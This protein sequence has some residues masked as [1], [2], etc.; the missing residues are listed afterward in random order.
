MSV[1][2]GCDNLNLQFIRNAFDGMVTRARKC[3][4][5]G[6]GSFPNE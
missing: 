1:R 3:I 6:G 5:V 2:E 4:A